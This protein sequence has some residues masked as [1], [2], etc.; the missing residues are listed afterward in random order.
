MAGPACHLVGTHKPV[1]VRFGVVGPERAFIRP[2]GPAVPPARVEGPGGGRSP[3][4]PSGP[5]GRP[6]DASCGWRGERLARW[7][8]KRFGGVDRTQPV[9]LGWGNGRPVGPVTELGRIACANRCPS[10]WVFIGRTPL[11]GA[12]SGVPG[13]ANLRMSPRWAS[14]HKTAW[15]GSRTRV[16]GARTSVSARWVSIGQTPSRGATSGVAG[17]AIV[18]RLLVWIEIHTT[19]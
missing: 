1:C 16:T 9:G 15:P 2:K 4:I 3:T 19:P 12:T 8:D 10:H 17:R 11:P 14:I 6:F 7:A 18:C 5:T 13:R